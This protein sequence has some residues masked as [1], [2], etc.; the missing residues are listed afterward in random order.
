M[1]N[2]LLICLLVFGFAILTSL[3][4]NVLLLRF[5]TT[6]GIRNKNDVIIRWSNQSKPSL[7]GVSFFIVFLIASIFFTILDREGYIFHNRK[8]IFF[9]IAGGMAFVMGLA[10]DAYNTKPLAK[11]LIQ[12]FCGVFL[13]FGGSVFNLFNNDFLN[14]G[15]TIFW[16]VL[17]MNSLNMLDNM[18]GITGT[19]CLFVLLSC[20]ISML[21]HSDFSQSIWQIL[22]IAVIGSIIGFLYHN[23]HPSKLFMGDAGSQFI[24]FFVA[25]MSIEF[26]ANTNSIS[27]SLGFNWQGLILVLIV[28]T[29][30][31]AD[32]VSVII[33]RL[34]KG[35]PPYVGGKDH[36]THHLVYKGKTDRQVWILFTSLAIFSTLIACVLIQYKDQ[37]SFVYWIIG[38][39]Y[40]ILVF[41]GL[42]YVTRK[43]KEPL[44]KVE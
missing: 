16:V 22:N 9:F 32:T 43:Y 38:L 37:L 39:M 29:V 40:P 4:V 24:G 42:F 34:S 41:I 8:F 1:S 6:L 12:I 2:Y 11:L 15:V 30:P 10:D 7:G 31:F 14:Y 25:F 5:S 17:L 44:K 23:I 36:T 27:A 3:F 28:F 33:N 26:L 35:I 13:C 21:Q 20:Q 18:D 19:V